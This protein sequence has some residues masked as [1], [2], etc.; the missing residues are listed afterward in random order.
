MRTFTLPL[1]AAGLLALPALPA[2]AAEP[3]VMDT[4]QLRLTLFPEN[5]RYR[6]LDKAADVT[7]ES[8]PEQSRFG[9]AT[10]SPGGRQQRVN[11]ARCDVTRA[12]EGLEAVFHP[13]ADQPAAALRVTLR[14]K[15]AGVLEV[16]CQADPA[17]AVENLRLLDSALWTD[18]AAGGSVVVPAREG[19]FIPADSGLNFTQRFGTYDYEGCHMAMFG[20][21]RHGAAALVTWE[22]PYVTLEVRSVSTN[23]PWAPGGQAL[24]PS[25]S[26]RQGARSFQIHFLGKGDYVAVAK[27][28]RQVAREKGWLVTWDRKLE[29]HPARAKYF[30]AS[31]FKLWSMLTRQMN[32]ESTRE[33][34]VKVEWTFAEAAQI[35]AHL[36]NDL[37]LERVLFILGGWIH[38]GYDNQHPDILPTA[39]ECGG[40]AAFAEACRRIRALGY[41]LC[42]HDNYQDIYRDSPSWDENLIQKNREGKAHRGRRV[43]GR[44]RL[45][46]L[47]AESRRTGPAAAEP[48][49]GQAALGRRLLFHRH[50]LRGRAAGVLRPEPSPDPAGRHE[51][52]AGHQRL[53]ARRCLAASAANAGANG[54]S[55]TATFSRG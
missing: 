44:T 3:V 24:L 38:R 20:I 30:G 5:G 6:I 50:H 22:D 1:F 48:R 28:Y 33:E 11:L 46:H 54:P 26:L 21:L 51:M 39:P 13:L 10:L 41:L 29:G 53:R 36:K 42:L 32:A 45:H 55:R 52:E 25:L 19:L 8:N 12:G 14:P 35:A 37:E 23:A 27:A 15:S 43:G 17:L 49:R 7:W 34:S 2:P 18:R 4:P 31:N 9:E 16:S 47:L 40:D